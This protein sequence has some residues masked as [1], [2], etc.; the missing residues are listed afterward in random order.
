MDIVLHLR[1][2]LRLMLYHLGLLLLVAAAGFVL[3]RAGADPFHMI[4]WFPFILAAGSFIIG[5]TLA[6]HPK[7]A[8]NAL[9]T[10]SLLVI[11]LLLFPVYALNEPVLDAIY[12][13]GLFHLPYGLLPLVE[14]FRP[15]DVLPF[16]LIPYLA[17][18]IGLFVKRGLVR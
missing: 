6:P 8:A 9:S 10:L 16:T 3:R 13:Y 14:S 2:N 18:T 15:V 12:M 1:N 7:A 4:G 5:L 17:A 11:S